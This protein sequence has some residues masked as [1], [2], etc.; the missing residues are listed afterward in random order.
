MKTWEFGVFLK[1]N[2]TFEPSVTHSVPEVVE[3]NF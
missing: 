3:N 2:K 1:G